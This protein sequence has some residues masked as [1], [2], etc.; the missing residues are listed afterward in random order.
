MLPI[1][2]SY[3]LEGDFTEHGATL[4]QLCLFHFGIVALRLFSV[5]I[6]TFLPSLQHTHHYSDNQ[7]TKSVDSVDGRPS[8]GLFR[9]ADIENGALLDCLHSDSAPQVDRSS[10][11]PPTLII[12]DSDS[13][14]SRNN[15]DTCQRASGKSDDVTS[16]PNT[17][18]Q[19]AFDTLRIELDRT[20]S[21]VDLPL[22]EQECRTKATT[23][24]GHHT[25]M[26]DN[27]HR[28]NLLSAPSQRDFHSEEETSFLR[29]GL[30][31]SVAIALHKIPEGFIIFSTNRIDPNLGFATFV[32]LLVHNLMEGFTVS[33]SLYMALRSRGSAI[34]WASVIGCGSQPLGAAIASLW[35]SVVKEMRPDVYGGFFAVTAGVMISLAFSLFSEALILTHRGSWCSTFVFLGMAIVSVTFVSTAT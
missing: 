21:Y 11:T 23:P 22:P 16:Y 10:I 30:E 3:L 35:F 1:S 28:L 29:I 5:F 31:S 20:Q 18:N 25:E 14:P 7:S 33:L 32:S 15:Q 12:V 4:L 9:D 24:D 6:G 34:A 27:D 26:L 17:C 8:D 2:R 13:G 19:S